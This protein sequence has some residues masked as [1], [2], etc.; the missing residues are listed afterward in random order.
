M[1]SWKRRILSFVFTVLIPFRERLSKY[2][3]CWIGQIINSGIQIYRG[4]NLWIMADYDLGK[5]HCIAKVQQPMC[6]YRQKVT[7][8]WL[9]ESNLLCRCSSL[10]PLCFDLATNPSHSW[11]SLSSRWFSISILIKRNF[12]IQHNLISSEST[13]EAIGWR[14]PE[15]QMIF[16]FFSKY[17]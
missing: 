10:S 5:P 13:S 9:V 12:S 2:A 17:G 8:L 1:T 6:T 14:K 3:I 15:N 7:S 11:A 16:F 4:Q